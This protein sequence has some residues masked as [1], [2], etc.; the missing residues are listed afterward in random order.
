[1]EYINSLTNNPLNPKNVQIPFGVFLAAEQFIQKINTSNMSTDELRAYKY[2]QSALMNKK[3]RILNRQSFT[4]II[5]AKTPAEKEDALQNYR[6]TK[7]L[8]K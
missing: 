3:S 6:E 4:E 8:Y 2:L 5:S 7:R 1:M